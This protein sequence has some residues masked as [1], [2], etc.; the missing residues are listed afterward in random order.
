[1]SNIDQLLPSSLALDGRA[2][3][4]FLTVL[5]TESV[6]RAANKLGVTQSAV[7]HTLEKLR[8]ILHDPLFVKSGRGIIPTSH[9]LSLAAPARRLLDDMQSLARGT[10][11]DPQKA[12]LS[13]IF[14]ANDYQGNLLLPGFYVQAAPKLKNLRMQIITS[15]WPTSELLREQRCDMILTPRPPEGSDILQ[16][17]IMGDRYACFFDG[18]V[19]TAPKTMDEYLAAQH[20]LT[21]YDGVRKLDFD[22]FLESEN[23]HRD[24]QL[25]VPNFAAVPP[26]LRGSD[27]VASMPGLLHAEI[28]EGFAVAPLPFEPPVL[29]MFMVWHKRHQE[30]PMHRWMRNELEASTKALL[31]RIRNKMIGASLEDRL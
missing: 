10:D 31:G 13:I 11:F 24:I 19:R 27:I 23:I 6:T 21:V 3:R 17:R 25:I 2:V 5:E 30:D 14:A 1:M 16:K 22:M 20:I 8:E 15:G 12:E 7:S 4:V 18:N 29:P 9:A 28:M 26:F